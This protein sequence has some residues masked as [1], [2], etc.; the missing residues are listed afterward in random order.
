MDISPQSTKCI[1]Y[2]PL[3]TNIGY[4]EMEISLQSTKC[5]NYYALITN[6]GYNKGIYRSQ[7]LRYNESSL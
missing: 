7:A 5:I 4:N 6:I 2:Y 1:N 3:I